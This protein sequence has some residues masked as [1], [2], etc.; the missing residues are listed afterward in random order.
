[1]KSLIKYQIGIKKEDINCDIH[2]TILDDGTFESNVK[3]HPW[4]W[5]H[6]KDEGWNTA[7]RHLRDYKLNTNLI[8]K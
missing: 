8:N 6:G 3:M 7:K 1:M 2:I 5:E 4:E